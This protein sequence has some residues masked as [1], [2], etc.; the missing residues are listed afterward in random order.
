MCTKGLSITQLAYHPDRVLYPMK[1][2]DKGWERISWDEALWT[3]APQVPGGDRVVAQAQHKMTET[4]I[5]TKWVCR[6]VGYDNEHIYLKYMSFGPCK[7]KRL[8][9]AGII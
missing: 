7:L 1:R 8:K 4:L 6:P 3:R 2:T 9:E 5:R